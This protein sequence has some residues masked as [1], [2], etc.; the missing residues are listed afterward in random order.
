ML[1]ERLQQQK[2]RTSR[3]VS[4]VEN[5]VLTNR[6]IGQRRRRARE[7]AEGV[8]HGQ[9]SLR[10]LATP[11]DTLR[12]C[13]PVARRPYDAFKGAMVTGRPRVASPRVLQTNA[14][15]SDVTIEN[16]VAGPRFS[17][18]LAERERVN[19]NVVRI[20]LLPILPL[21]NTAFS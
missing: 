10:H 9:P 15:D 14:N 1:A 18:C 20:V 8:I 17:D 21:F 16:A 13:L 5:G 2:E 3:A 19:P 11:R 12:S 6:Q 7:R 4:P